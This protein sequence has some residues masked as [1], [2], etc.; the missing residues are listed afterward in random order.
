MNWSLPK[1]II[2]TN[3]WFWFWLKMLTFHRSVVGKKWLNYVHIGCDEVWHLGE[4]SRCR[5]H[6]SKD[7]FLSHV[8]KMAKYVREKYKL[9]PIIWDDMLRKFYA[10]ELQKSRIGMISYILSFLNEL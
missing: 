7:L 10:D 3:F 8:T 6:D 1:R 2:D 4:C 9:I 5:N